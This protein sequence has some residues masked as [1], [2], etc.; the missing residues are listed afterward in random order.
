MPKPVTHHQKAYETL[1]SSPPFFPPPQDRLTNLCNEVLMN[2]CDY[3]ALYVSPSRMTYCYGFVLSHRYYTQSSG[4]STYILPTVLQT[5]FAFIGA[6]AAFFV[7]ASCNPIDYIDTKLEP[8]LGKDPLKKTAFVALTALSIIELQK[9]FSSPLEFGKNLLF[10]SI[11]FI[12]LEEII[13]SPTVNPLFKF[14]KKD[15]SFAKEVTRRINTSVEFLHWM[16]QKSG[17]PFP[18]N[19]A[20]I[21]SDLNHFVQ[22]SFKRNNF[23]RSAQRLESSMRKRS[24]SRKMKPSSIKKLEANIKAT[25]EKAMDKGSPP[26][27]FIERYLDQQERYE[28]NPNTRTYL[29]KRVVEY[30]FL[31]FI[32]ITKA[33]DG[34]SKN[35]LDK[36]NT[37]GKD[38]FI[39]EQSIE[40]IKK[41]ANE[42][43]QLLGCVEQIF[44]D[45]AVNRTG[46]I[47]PL[48]SYF[49]WLPN[50]FLTERIVRN[51]LWACSLKYTINS[52]TGVIDL[53]AEKIALYTELFAIFQK[54]KALTARK[55][56]CLAER[57]WMLTFFSVFSLQ[58][59]VSMNN[60]TFSGR[61]KEFIHHT[62]SLLQGKGSNIPSEQLTMLAKKL[63]FLIKAA[64]TE[65]LNRP[66]ISGMEAKTVMM[67]RKK[68]K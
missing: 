64:Y 67:R 13:F 39:D 50:D 48:L 27:C 10:G 40:S 54:K 59:K 7:S 2:L 35:D 5:V 32:L 11:F 60:V 61:L 28:E 30:F 15:P 16:L 8:F 63:P 38:L 21:D 37:I 31:K 49:T 14:V 4:E 65:W 51:S 18:D 9:Y 34:L 12:I 41:H 17:V 57:F 58:S 29:K 44:I 22:E 43:N 46:K 45:I 33:S 36:L 6:T 56:T 1:Y 24:A 3:L 23:Y 47:K 66:Q 55:K 52:S 42:L 53:H 62:A 26:A 19:A 20:R 25:Y 68:R